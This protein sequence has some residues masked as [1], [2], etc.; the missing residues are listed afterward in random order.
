M[1]QLR[2]GPIGDDKPI[3]L[4]LEISPALL[5]EIVRYSEVHARATGRS[6]PL[7]PEKLIPPIVELFIASDREFIKQLRRRDTGEIGHG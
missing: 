1:S 3:K 7:A 2:L 5:N 6:A 4:S